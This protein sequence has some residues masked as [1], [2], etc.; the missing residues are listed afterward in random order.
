V[1]IGLEKL[2]SNVQ[3]EAGVYGNMNLQEMERA[4]NACVN[5]P[6]V[7]REAERLQLA[8]NT[9]LVCEPWM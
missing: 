9:V 5:H 2:V 1:N 6:L 7:R 8:E 3:L 4:S